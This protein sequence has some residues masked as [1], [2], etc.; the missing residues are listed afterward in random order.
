MKTVTDELQEMASKATLSNEVKTLGVH[1]AAKQAFK[2][3][4]VYFHGLGLKKHIDVTMEQ[5]GQ[6]YQL[7]FKPEPELNSISEEKTVL[8]TATD[9]EIIFKSEEKEEKSESQEE[10]WDEV[11]EFFIE[12]HYSNE[13]PS[14]ARVF[15]ELQEQFILTRK[16]NTL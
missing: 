12:R 5:D 3:L 13:R 6:K 15:S 7:L 11:T 16:E 14:L 10:L 2:I 9:V 4:F 1:E 8:S